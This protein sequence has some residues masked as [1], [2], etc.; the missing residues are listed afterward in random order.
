MRGV[1][2]VTGLAITDKTATGSPPTRW[3]TGYGYPSLSIDD[4]ALSARGAVVA[5]RG[6][7][8]RTTAELSTWRDSRGRA[9]PRDPG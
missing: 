4:G 2:L 7:L 6:T 5:S 9:I 3:A 1:P 8:A